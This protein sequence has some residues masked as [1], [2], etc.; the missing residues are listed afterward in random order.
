MEKYLDLKGLQYLCRKMKRELDA[1]QGRLTGQPGQVVGLDEQG[2]RALMLT[3]GRNVILEQGRSELTIHAVAPGKNLLHNW[4]FTAP[5]NQ[6][7]QAEYSNTDLA[8]TIDR[9][10]CG[11]GNLKLD[12]SGVFITWNG[13]SES[14]CLT[15]RISDTSLSFGTVVTA[16]LLT[17][18]GMQTFTCT[19]TSGMAAVGGATSDG[20]LNILHQNGNFE[21]VIRTTTVRGR[22]L[23]AAK[24]ELGPVQ[25]LAHQD[26]DGNWMLSDPP[27]NPALELLMCQRYYWKSEKAFVLCNYYNVNYGL[28]DVNFPIQMRS[29]PTCTITSVNGTSG[30]LSEWAMSYDTNI[31]VYVNE[32]GLCKTGF[33]GINTFGLKVFNLEEKYSF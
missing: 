26:A 16:S 6:R 8:Y 13:S 5:I 1:K 11:Q 17:N 15:Q 4:Y 19:I 33:S 30:V 31:K 25:T 29:V 24:L 10:L 14:C 28:S 23:I 2:A 32:G 27:P 7:G 9:W 21:F 3:R 22:R 18:A 12:A 20:S